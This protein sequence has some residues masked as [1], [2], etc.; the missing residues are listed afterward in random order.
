VAFVMTRINVGDYD[1]WKARF[2]Q[3]APGARA[4]SKGHRLFRNVEQPNEVYIQVE[5]ASVDDARLARERLLSSGVLDR[6][7]DKSG[8]TVIEEA[9]TVKK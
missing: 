2:D 9:E 8:P 7:T 1:A 4:S 5:Y 3:D 6:F